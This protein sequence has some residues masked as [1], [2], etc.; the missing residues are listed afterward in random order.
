MHAEPWA[1]WDCRGG[2]A[3]QPL[4][5]A[6]TSPMIN[7][8][9]HACALNAQAPSSSGWRSRRAGHTLGAAAPVRHA[10][11]PAGRTCG[12]QVGGWKLQQLRCS[13]CACCG[14]RPRAVG[15]LQSSIE[16]PHEGLHAALH[17]VSSCS[18]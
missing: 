2:H 18:A 9:L 4:R 13:A 17:A 10:G 14:Y 11:A 1:Q 15:P 16:G 8:I 7:P 6:P 3:P 12:A 5:S